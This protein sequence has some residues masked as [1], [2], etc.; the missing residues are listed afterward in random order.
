[1]FLE[2]QFV[3]LDPWVVSNVLGPNIEAC[4]AGSSALVVGGRAEAF[5]KHA[6]QAAAGAGRAFDYVRCR[7]NPRPQ[8][9]GPDLINP[10]S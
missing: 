6:K 8:T 1:V 9:L 2:S 4:G 10:K 5:L 3:E 7:P